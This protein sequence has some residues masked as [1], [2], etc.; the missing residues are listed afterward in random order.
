MVGAC[1][2]LVKDNNL[3]LQLRTDNGCW[4]LPGGALEPGESLEE[5]AKR[6]LFEEIGLKALKL[7]LMDVYS[8][9][10]FYYKYP[11]GDEVFNVIAAYI[12]DDFVGEF[13]LDPD[14]V[15]DIR[16]FELDNLPSA[17]SPPDKPIVQA[18]INMITQNNGKSL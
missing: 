2:L 6:E 12:C 13:I 18:Y 3:L 15:S 11:H 5:V 4:G 7:E 16:F 14:E 8:G 9:R 1:V 10:D 17:I